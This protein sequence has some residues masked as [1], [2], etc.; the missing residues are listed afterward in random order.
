MSNA[1]PMTAITQT[2]M[3]LMRLLR[4][5][6]PFETK[7]GAQRYLR[8][9]STQTGK[10]LRLPTVRS[11]IGISEEHGFP[12][13]T[14]SPKN[15]VPSGIAVMFHGGAYVRLPLADHWKFAD[16]LVQK[17]GWQVMLPLYPKAPNAT[18]SA[19]LAKVMPLVLQVLHHHPVVFMGDSA[20]GGF[21]LALCEMLAKAHQPQ[22][23]QLI[24]MSPW[25]DI[26]L[27]NPQSDAL[28]PLD[29]ILACEGLREIGRVWSGGLSADD[30]QVSPLRGL[31]S[32]LPPMTVITGDHEIFYPDA[33][34]LA[35][36][37]AHLG[38]EVDLT[39]GKGLFHCYPLFNVPES[40]PVLNS[41]IQTLNHF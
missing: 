2:V 29:P 27:R 23:A 36:Q 4:F 5:K 11:M 8:Q 18:A 12:V 15:K 30:P 1:T 28:E 13:V 25:L 14:L 41:I 19:S 6:R 37:A 17:T 20:G 21:A 16:R 7:A 34:T 22:P 9:H 26:A 38:I 3:T 39:I 10:P 32:D 24:L 35:R 33:L 31:T 40:Q